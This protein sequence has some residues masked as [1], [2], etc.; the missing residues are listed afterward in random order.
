MVQLFIGPCHMQL[1][2]DERH[3]SSDEWQLRHAARPA[4]PALHFV[5][6]LVTPSA[7]QPVEP[8]PA[9]SR[10]K[11]AKPRVFSRAMWHTGC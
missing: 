5:T 1:I 2:S 6:P 11:P 10:E 8:V 4:A 9:L 7:I 3:P